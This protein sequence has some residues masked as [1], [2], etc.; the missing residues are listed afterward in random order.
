[1]YRCRWGGSALRSLP[2]VGEEQEF[3]RLTDAPGAPESI[4]AGLMGL[5]LLADALREGPA[6]KLVL[7]VVLH[8]ANTNYFIHLWADLDNVQMIVNYTL[9]KP[10]SC[11]SD[12]ELVLGAV[13]QDVTHVTLFEIRPHNITIMMPFGVH[14]LY[15]RVATHFPDGIAHVTVDLVSF[16]RRVVNRLVSEMTVVLDENREWSVQLSPKDHPVSTVS[17]VSALQS[18]QSVSCI[19]QIQIPLVFLSWGNCNSQSLVQPAVGSLRATCA[20]R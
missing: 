5:L 8:L 9:N 7:R 1:M 16:L 10:G 3:L 14:E 19:G 17:R 15:L 4:V 20:P 2:D 11:P 18:V 12:A 13:H 6:R